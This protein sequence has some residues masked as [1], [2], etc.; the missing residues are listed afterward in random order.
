MTTPML[1]LL[2]ADRNI[3]ELFLELLKFVFVELGHYT[4]ARSI[5]EEI[6]LLIM[7]YLLGNHRL[8]SHLLMLHLLGLILE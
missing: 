5:E 2:A 1:A 4:E 3:W 6:K 8:L 7:F